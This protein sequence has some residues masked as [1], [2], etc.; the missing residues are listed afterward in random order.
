[1]RDLIRRSAA[2]VGCRCCTSNRLA[3]ACEEK[4]E[5]LECG[6]GGVLAQAEL[7]PQG[8]EAFPAVFRELGERSE[9]RS[10]GREVRRCLDPGV[11]EHHHHAHV[12][13]L[14]IC[15][16]F[17]DRD[18]RVHVLLCHDSQHL[19]RL[20]RSDAVAVAGRTDWVP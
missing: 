10:V 13:A 19:P 12:R 4:D 18:I 20:V 2:L 9:Q 14:G 8:I 15:T 1:M 5:V 3:A 6:R 7:L 16:P 11:Q 17:S